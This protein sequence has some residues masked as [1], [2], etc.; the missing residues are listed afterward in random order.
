MTAPARQP[1]VLD[2]NIVLDL[3]VFND[4]AAQPLKRALEAGELDWLATQAMRD[5]LERVLAYPQIIP[6]L[7]FY[8]LSAGDVLAAFDRHVRLTEVAAKAG[9][10]CS[11]PDD[12]KFIDLAVAAKALLLSKDRAVLS[13]AKRLLTQEVRAQAAI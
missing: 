13:M 4:A 11:D 1:I 12:Q 2:T 10:T 5:E 3:F 9:V 6:R 8:E 7:A